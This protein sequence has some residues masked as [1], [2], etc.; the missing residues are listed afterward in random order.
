MMMRRV[1]CRHSS[2]VVSV[3]VAMRKRRRVRVSR[4]CCGHCSGVVPVHVRVVL[5][6]L[7]MGLMLLMV[8]M[9]IGVQGHIRGGLDTA[10]VRGRGGHAY[11]AA[12]RH[13]PVGFG[14]PESSG[15]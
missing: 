3:R 4:G 7:L 13:P 12:G 10:W 11:S 1:R 2:L 5:L 9:V 15:L 8:K 14:P 6:L